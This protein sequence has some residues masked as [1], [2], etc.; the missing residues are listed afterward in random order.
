[1]SEK[2]S[3]TPK[4]EISFLNIDGT[5][6]KT[7]L[8]EK[9]ENRTVWDKPN[10]KKLLS[11]IPGTINKV[12]VEKGQTVKKG[13]KVVILEAMKMQNKILSSRDGVIKQVYVKEG[14]T[15][16]KGGLILELK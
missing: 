15:L 14:Q 16:P 13:E 4:K 2:K 11:F 10:D 12:F 5:H 8:T 1:M 6:Y 7:R 9:F 3:N